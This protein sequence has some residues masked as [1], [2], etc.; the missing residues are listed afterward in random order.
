MQTVPWSCAWDVNNS[1]YMYT[2]LQNGMVLQFDRRQ[3][4]RPVESMTGLTGNP[5]HTVR[6]LSADPTLGAGV[7]S[8]LSASSVGLCHWNFGSSDERPCLIP[9]SE[10]QGICIS[11]ACGDRNDDIVA[12]FRPKLEISGDMAAS[13]V[14]LTPV[15]TMEQ[16][17]D[18]SHVLYRRMGCRYQKLVAS[19]AKVS[20]IRLPKSAIIDR[21]KNSMFAAG[22]ETTMEL[23]LQE[24]PSLNVAQRIKSLNRPIRDVRYARLQNSGLLGCLSEDK[25]QLCSH[26]LQ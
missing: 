9:E 10:N 21:G 11:L 14:L 13:Q 5:V 6:S 24:L 4:M 26:K 2:G 3:T 16:A 18:G 17:V 15:S 7:R 25:L 12:S 1:H 22:D 23:V 8:V 20:G 19:C